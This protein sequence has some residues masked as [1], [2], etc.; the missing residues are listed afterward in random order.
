VEVEEPQDDDDDDDE[1]GEEEGDGEGDD[2]GSPME[3]VSATERGRRDGEALGAAELHRPD[4]FASKAPP[5][6]GHEWRLQQLR[7][8]GFERTC[9]HLVSNDKHVD[10]V[11]R[12]RRVLDLFE[13]RAASGARA[14]V[15][16][17]LRER[18]GRLNPSPP[19]PS[20]P[21]GGVF[22]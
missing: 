7:A 13:T 15:P 19:S 17:S 6:S 9:Q 14:N 12:A 18:L 16:L 2:R 11:G 20:S 8:L 5:L 22:H 21:S 1:A 3:A 10:V 4:G